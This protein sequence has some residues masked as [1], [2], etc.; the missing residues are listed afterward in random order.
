LLPRQPTLLIEA[1]A[2][3][4]SICLAAVA[5]GLTPRGL[6]LELDE[7]L[8][9]FWAVV[10]SSRAP[11]LAQ[12]VVEFELTTDSVR[13][14]LERP[15][16]DDV[17][18]AFRLLLRNRV[19]RGGLL[20]TG[21][22]LLRE[23]EDGRGLGS[24]YYPA[25]LARRIMTASALRDRLAVE[26]GDGLDALARYGDSPD[27][28]FFVDPPYVGAPG[29]PGARLYRHAELDHARLFSLVGGLTSDALLSYQDHPR[30]RALAAGSQLECRRVTMHTTHHQRTTELLIGR[31]LSWLTTPRASRHPMR[32]PDSLSCRTRPVELATMTAADPSS[33]KQLVSLDEAASELAISRRTVE[34]LITDGE[35]ERVR[36][37]GRAHVT[38]DSLAA[39]KRRRDGRSA[40]RDAAGAG[41]AALTASVEALADAVRRDRGELLD[42]LR[43]REELRVELARVSA[44]LDAERARREHLECL[45][46]VAMPPPR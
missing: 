23:G 3:G 14:E 2:G 10:L 28:A 24:R 30:V 18:R 5:E 40:Q 16:G 39:L 25:T 15:D 9:R 37:G 41:V 46:Q 42:A 8:A 29:S 43:D 36:T 44:E 33:A 26:H 6:M 11:V 13:A 4:G 21:S 20:T 19:S 22:G 12:R 31:D 45:Q 1:F 7:E 35:L 38:T 17:D 27:I 34:R 32:Q